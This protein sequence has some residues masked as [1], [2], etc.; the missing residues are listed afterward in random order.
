MF[1][2]L[3]YHKKQKISKKTKE[4]E[5]KQKISKKTK[6]NEKRKTGKSSKK[7]IKK[8]KGILNCF[9]NGSL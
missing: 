7:K 6:E 8:E 3:S 4:N 1:Q 9:Y 5:R 2:F